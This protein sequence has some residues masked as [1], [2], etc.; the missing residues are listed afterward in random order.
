MIYSE[1]IKD[2]EFLQ[3]KN[4]FF[5]EDGV[6]IR[7]KEQLHYYEIYRGAFGPPVADKSHRICPA[8]TSNVPDAAVFCTTCGEFPI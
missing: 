4:K 8:C 6:R 2:S 7:D 5:A 3:K 1:R